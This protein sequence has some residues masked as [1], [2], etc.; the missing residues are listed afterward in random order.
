MYIVQVKRIFPTEAWFDYAKTSDKGE[1]QTKV[2]A[3]IRAGHIPASVRV[4]KAVSKINATVEVT[5]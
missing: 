2:N 3:L 5:E 1:V 4:V